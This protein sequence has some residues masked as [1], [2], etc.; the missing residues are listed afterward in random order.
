[1]FIH[2]DG[3]LIYPLVIFVCEMYISATYK[4]IYY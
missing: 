2:K 4:N 3:H 1:M